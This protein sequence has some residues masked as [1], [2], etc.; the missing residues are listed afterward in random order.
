[1]QITLAHPSASS[2]CTLEVGCCPAGRRPPPPH[3]ADG[4]FPASPCSPAQGLS[5]LHVAAGAGRAD[6][7]EHLLDALQRAGSQRQPKAARRALSKAVRGGPAER[8]G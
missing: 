2:Y 3:R 1:M 8:N 4:P 6:L 5:C 7:L